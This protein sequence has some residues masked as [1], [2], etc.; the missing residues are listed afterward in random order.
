MATN[1]IGTVALMLTANAQGVA[2]GV[3][4]ALG[5]VSNLFSGIAKFASRT[6]SI[7]L[8]ILSAKAFSAAING[9]KE[10]A[11]WAIKTAEEYEQAEIAFQVMTGSKVKGTKLLGDLQQLAVETP[12][13]SSEVVAQAKLLK[14]YGVDTED[15]IKTISQLGDVAAGTLS[16]VRWSVVCCHC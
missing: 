3:N 12:F 11:Q 10:L 16:C 9:A 4:S 7:S 8:G 6:A 13:K 5:S 15:L 1:K 2:N 14:A